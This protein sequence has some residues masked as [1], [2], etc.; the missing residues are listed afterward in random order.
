M[1]QYQKEIYRKLKWNRYINTQKSESKMI[2]NFE[3]VY[4]DPT[5]TVV[6]FGD[7]SKKTNLKGK[8]PFIT[9]KL[10]KL[11]RLAK[12][13]LYLINEF[14][15]SKLC[16]KCH[17]EVENFLIR[18]SK[19]PKHKGKEIL[20]WGLVCCTNE[21]CKPNTKSLK[22]INKY[23]SNV[24]NRDTNA[25][26]NE[27]LIVRHLIKTGECPQQYIQPPLQTHSH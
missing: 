26:L 5:N 4:G 21:K 7:Y 18:N 22:R 15:T 24:Y 23:G 20:V 14:R 16:H 11:L 25:V 9:K 13:R 8:E 27:H 1:E 2:K 17:S 10:K 12:Y 3:A 6:I 19:K